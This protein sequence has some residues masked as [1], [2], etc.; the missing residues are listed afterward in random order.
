MA[1]FVSFALQAL[2]FVSA[3][4]ANKADIGVRKH[5][6]VVSNGEIDPPNAKDNQPEILPD[7]V[8]THQVRKHKDSLLTDTSTENDEVGFEDTIYTVDGVTY[9]RAGGWICDPNPATVLDTDISAA[10]NVTPTQCLRQCNADSNCTC[11]RYL[12]Y[13]HNTCWKAHACPTAGA[14]LTQCNRTD[15]FDVYIRQASTPA[16]AALPAPI[17]AVTYADLGAGKCLANGQDPTYEY[18]PDQDHACEQLCSDSSVC[19]G[20]S[21]SQWNCLLWTQSGLA[22]GGAGWGDAHCH[23]KAA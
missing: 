23:V 6:R 13:Y 20:Y 16:P 4:V 17:Q 1:R 7:A 11:T 3:V 9:R 15:R 18:H 22:A 2:A 10:V 19:Y 5:V 8:R 21:A 12:R 14:N